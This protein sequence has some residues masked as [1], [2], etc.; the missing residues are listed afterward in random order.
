MGSQ[1]TSYVPSSRPSAKAIH[2]HG[3]ATGQLL[4][5]LADLTDNEKCVTGLKSH[6]RNNLVDV[7]RKLFQ[8]VDSIFTL[9]A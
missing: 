2:S 5:L 9:K 6:V 1:G 3:P 4:L 8:S 7:L